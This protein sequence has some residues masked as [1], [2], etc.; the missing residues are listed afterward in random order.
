M[1][2]G[3][4]VP[5]VDYKLVVDGSEESA[6]TDAGDGT[7]VTQGELWMRGPQ[8]MLGYW[9]NPVGTK[10][11]I[12]DGWYRTGDVAVLDEHGF[13]TIVDRVKD[14]IISGGLNVYPAEVERVLDEHPDLLEACVVGLP[15]D[16]WGEVV[17]AAVV[18]R[19]GASV[20]RG[21]AGRLVR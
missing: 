7:E 17:A 6:A 5:A 20:G 4:P 8:L 1:P 9:N 2:T 13:L 14:M 18:P 15:D 12:V 19:E 10:E 3:R 16:R 21:G 11:A